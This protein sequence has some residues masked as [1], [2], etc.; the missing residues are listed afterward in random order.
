M[1]SHCLF[2]LKDT[3]VIDLTCFIFYIYMDLSVVLLLYNT[4]PKTTF[5]YSILIVFYPLKQ[6]IASNELYDANTWIKFEIFG[7]P[8]RYKP[9]HPSIKARFFLKKPKNE[10]AQTFFF[11]T[12]LKPRSFFTPL[13]SIKFLTF[14]TPLHSPPEA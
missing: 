11:S 6:C 3:T 12:K 4:V 8:N 14:S 5:L 9:Q 10:G 7:I 1:S 13:E 2:I